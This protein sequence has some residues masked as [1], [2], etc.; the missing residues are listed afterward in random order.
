[1]RTKTK[2]KRVARR[3]AREPQPS[4]PK[5][6][7]RARTAAEQGISCLSDVNGSPCGDAAVWFD[8]QLGEQEFYKG[9]VC[10]AHRI[11]NR[12]EKLL[13]ERSDA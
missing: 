2:K 4:T 8:Y 7:R 9:F 10:D 6:P 13:Q 3:P 11:S 12:V 5:P 1:M